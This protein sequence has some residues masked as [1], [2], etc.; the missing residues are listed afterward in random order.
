MAESQSTQ[1]GTAK[2]GQAKQ[3]PTEGKCIRCKGPL[4]R[5]GIRCQKC[6]DFRAKK[7]RKQTGT[8][9]KCGGSTGKPEYRVCADCRKVVVYTEGEPKYL[10]RRCGEP[11]APSERQFCRECKRQSLNTAQKKA[12]EKRKAAGLCELC[13]QPNDMPTGVCTNCREKTKQRNQEIKRKCMEAYG[14]CCECCGEKILDFLT[15]DHR[16]NDGHLHRASGEFGGIGGINIYRWALKNGCPKN[17]RAMCW[18]CNLGRRLNGG[19]CPHELL[20]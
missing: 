14:G 9:N 13:C 3:M 5:T 15:L 7:S 19:T 16:D 12:R 1:N 2:Q 18:N 10:C 17:L 11:K 20:K 8:C 6:C 4:D